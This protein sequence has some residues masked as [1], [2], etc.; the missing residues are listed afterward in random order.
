[1]YTNF[2][3]GIDKCGTEWY[4]N[5]AVSETDDQETL[6]KRDEMVDIPKFTNC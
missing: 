6:K 2:K 5:Q 3:K 1:M 4:N